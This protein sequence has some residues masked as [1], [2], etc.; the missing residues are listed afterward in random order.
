MSAITIATSGDFKHL[1]RYLKS[2]KSLKY[3]KVLDKFGRRGVDAL[4]AAT[5]VDSGLTANSWGYE[6]HDTSSGCELVWTNSNVNDGVNVAVILQYG[7]GTGTGGYVPGRDY[8]NPALRKV[9]DG[10]LDEILKA[11]NNG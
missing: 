6:I 1:D 4:R 11:V 3:R 10:L 8:I 5:P 9:L 2:L 7:H